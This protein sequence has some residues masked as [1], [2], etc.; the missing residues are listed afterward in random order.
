LAHNPFIGPN[1]VLN[2]PGDTTP[3]VQV[4][5]GDKTA[6]G[7]FLL[8][9]GA[10]ASMIS[11]H[12]ASELNVRYVAGTEG[13]DNP[14]LEIF[15][16]TTGQ[17]VMQLP[18]QFK[19]TIGGIGGQTTVA[20]FYLDSLMLHVMAQNG[21]ILPDNDPNNLRF[22]GAPV[23]VHDI[24]LAGAT[25]DQ[26]ITLDG[27]LGMNFLTSS[28]NVTVNGSDV[29]A[30]GYTPGAFDW[31]TFDETNGI[32]GLALNSQFALPT[33]GDFNGDG[34]VDGADLAAW[35]SNFPL[36]SGGTLAAGDSDGDGD[37]DGADFIA[38]Q[39]HLGAGSGSGAS[40]V[41][42]PGAFILALSALAGWWL[43]KRFA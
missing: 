27:I 35:Q 40:P 19:L 10:A 8:D 34:K 13:T 26:D 39:T 23:L 24:T 14:A 21:G 18:D 17:G 2:A 12:V 3:P 37:V 36:A 33:P 29:A 6:Q 16:P 7:S 4:S 9:T 41:P 42:E 31:V 43:R 5:L 1:P 28:V 15:N 32:L 25:P 20:G 30:D 22:V 38:W 11:T